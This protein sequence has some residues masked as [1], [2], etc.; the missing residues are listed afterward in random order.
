MNLDELAAATTT[1]RQPQ[2]DLNANRAYHLERMERSQMFQ[3]NDGET[4]LFDTQENV[5]YQTN[6]KWFDIDA[7]TKDAKD[8]V[9]KTNC[10]L[11]TF[12]YRGFCSDIILKHDEPLIVN[13]YVSPRREHEKNARG[14]V[15]LATLGFIRALFP[16]QECQEF[17]FDWLA[18]SLVR[19]CLTYVILYTEQKGV[20][21]GILTELWTNLHGEHN[22][23]LLENSDFQSNFNGQHYGKTAIVANELEIETVQQLSKLKRYVDDRARYERKGKDAIVAKSYASIIMSSNQANCVRLDEQERR[24]SVPNV[25]E[26]KLEDQDITKQYGGVENLRNAMLAEVPEFYQWL[27]GRTI[28]RD[29]T[30]GYR[31]SKYHKMVEEQLSEWAKSAES[32][33]KD[34]SRPN[35]R[36]SARKLQEHLRNESQTCPGVHK[37]A[38]HFRSRQSQGFVVSK[39]GN[40]FEFGYSGSGRTIAFPIVHTT[41]TSTQLPTTRVINV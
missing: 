14:V 4:Y 5:L 9:L 17:M 1:H 32:F 34:M 26:M 39:S 12:E 29:M 36:I 8:R 15:P 35:Q 30:R 41:T 33:V 25:S 37:I 3:D 38:K 7:D 18:N 22:T 40:D 23:S 24:F 27:S 6:L 11:A 28:T 31:S 21:K 20:G 16:D 10:V 13:T 2:A 19:K